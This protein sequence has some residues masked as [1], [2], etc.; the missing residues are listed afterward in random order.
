MK[1][2]N[3]YKMSVRYPDV[4]FIDSEKAKMVTYMVDDYGNIGISTDRGLI[5]M[6]KKQAEAVAKELQEVI[7]VWYNKK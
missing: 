5:V 4:T 1:E 3:A 6:T 7:E 2:N